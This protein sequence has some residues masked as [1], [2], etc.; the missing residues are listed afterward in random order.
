MVQGAVCS[1]DGNGHMNVC[2]VPQ[3]GGIGAFN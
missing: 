2:A 1:R 3:L